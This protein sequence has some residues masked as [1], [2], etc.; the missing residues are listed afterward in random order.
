M[1]HI[2]Y[3]RSKNIG[4]ENN[5]ITLTYMHDTSLVIRAHG[6]Q[7]GKININKLYI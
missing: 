7:K 5:N 4:C 3:S 1:A 2:F 6:K